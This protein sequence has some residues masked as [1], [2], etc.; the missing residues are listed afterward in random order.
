MAHSTDSAPLFDRNALFKPFGVMAGEFLEEFAAF[1]VVEAG[2][3]ANQLFRLR[4][5]GGDDFG[6]AVT[7]QCDAVA[8]HAVHVFFAVYVPERGGFASG[9]DDL[10]FAKDVCHQTVFCV[11]DF[12]FVH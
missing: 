12:L 6:V 8:A 10:A 9:Y 7:E 3:A 5:D 11:Y 1:V 4:F 2:V